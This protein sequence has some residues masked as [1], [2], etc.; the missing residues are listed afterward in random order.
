MKTLK[1]SCTPRPSVF[2]RSKRDTALDLTDLLEKKIN[3]D[4]FFAEN[5][6]TEG[7]KVLL[8]ESF[9]RFQGIS[10]QGVFL[11]SQA[12]GGGKTHNMVVLGLLA[13]YP[14]LRANVLGDLY[15]NA[16]IGEVRVVGFTGRESDA[17]YG[18]W[19]SIATQL[20][21]TEEFNN[22]YS[23]LAAP[24]QTA[25]IK[26]LQGEPLLI[27]LD[28]LPPYFENARSKPIGNSDLARVTTTALANLLVAVGK[29]EL[30][31]VCV[32]ISDLKATY[33]GGSEQITKA[34]EDF[35]NEVGRSAINLEPVG[36]NNDDIY[37]ILRQ[38]LF[39]KLPEEGEIIQIAQ[40]YAQAVRDAKQM[41][42]TNASP[43]KF[44]TQLQQSYPFH[45]SL[46]DLY[47]RF[48]Q[49][50]GFQQTRGLIRLMRALVARLYDPQDT[51]ADS[52]YL[53]HPY[54]LDLNDS[55]T[56][57]EIT[58][59]N[60]SLENAIS[61]DIAANGNAIAEIMDSNLGG[62]DA[63]D[64]CTL[65]L[66]SSLANIPDAV[67]GLSVP[68][69][70]SYLCSPGRDISKLP[71][72]V[73]GN[74][75]TKA[76]Y[77][78]SNP[79]GKLYFKNVENLVARLNTLA[80]SYNRETSVK[81]LREFLER[82]FQPS[83]KDCYQEV[84]ALRPLD[85]IEIKGDRVT[86]IIYEPYTE[87]S[88]LHPDLQKRYDDLEYKNRIMFLSGVRG[89]IEK[90]V[91]TAAELKAVNH[92]LEEMKAQKVPNNDPQ[93]QAAQEIQ[94]R[95]YF[96]L[97]SMTKETFMKLYF[98]QNEQIR[99]ADFIM[100]F[101]DNNYNGEQ[102]IRETL[103][104]KEKFT[105][106]VE[107]DTF[108]KKCEQRLFS[109]KIMPWSEIKNRAATNSYWP[110]HRKDALD[111][112]KEK[113]LS[114]DQWRENGG[115][116]EK[117]PFPK[118]Q[119]DIRWQERDRNDD[120]GEVI[121]SLTPI[122]GDRIHYEIGAPATS[123]SQIVTDAKDFRTQALEISFLCLDSA[124]E[125]ETGEAK[126]WRNRLTLKSRIYQQG[127]DK[128][129]EL[130]S[131]PNAPIRYTTDGSDPKISGG[132]YEGSF[133]VPPA[134]LFVLA[135][136]EK[137]GLV[138]E[139]HRLEIKWDEREESRLDPD[140]STIWKKE[141]RPSTTQESY[142][143]L[144]LVKK[145]GARVCGPKITIDGQNWIELSTDSQLSFDGAALEEILTHLRGVLS[146]G[147]IQI[148]TRALKFATGQSLLDWV[149]EVKTSLAKNEVE[150]E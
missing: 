73:L 148:D 115:Y 37:H 38:R 95:I 34:L 133:L 71:R 78:H 58:N 107:S 27:L 32:V 123:A 110:W 18:I 140:K 16:P 57:S 81:K 121:L 89:T 79:E 60:S 55:D 84:Y 92:I 47:A 59:I 4:E 122:H 128:M 82:I 65:L 83:L 45:F 76:W 136:A 109:Q 97:L 98:P 138:S 67:V 51:Q 91:E 14:S 66:I 77:L 127:S 42:I 134:T 39:E 49:N 100:T 105:E 125:H 106:D 101:Q 111:R 29:N 96:S 62:R 6:L 144:G 36:F 5:Y 112:L 129:V 146:Q 52:I 50:P 1:E 88:G 94:D 142:E 23:P 132:N 141:H 17:P 13:Q 90:L 135:V 145:H 70:I 75:A 12:M 54:N 61:H 131:A 41:D 102:Q 24:G 31:N 20:G 72:D 53:I 10:N 108:R 44:A 11:L 104:N 33:E 137:Q 150:Q 87:I 26:L 126:L 103:L 2:D 80:D 119:T 19:G 117:P 63:K 143:F 8:R 130:R 149:A 118:P 116:L 30:D 22:Y 56:R 43:E 120:T 35:K 86:L 40:A 124:T 74:L 93:L 46:R 7:M 25:W 85:E 113:L 114:Q 64:A 139:I 69:I 3:P 21:K 68:E 15:E 48:R 147:E 9:R 28:E 99:T